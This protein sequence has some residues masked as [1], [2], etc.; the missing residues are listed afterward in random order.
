MVSIPACHAGDRGSIPRRGGRRPF[1]PLPP[2]T[3]RPLSDPVAGA[4]PCPA[5]PRPALPSALHLGPWRH[6][7]RGTAH[8]P[9]TFPSNPPGQGAWSPASHSSLLG[10]RQRLMS[11]PS[12][13]DG[14][15]PPPGSGSPTA[16]QRL[17]L[18]GARWRAACR[19]CA[20]S[21]CR[22]WPSRAS[23]SG[24]DVAENGRGL[25]SRRCGAGVPRGQAAAG[26]SGPGVALERPAAGGRPEEASGRAPPSGGAEEGG[27]GACGER[28]GSAGAGRR[29][30]VL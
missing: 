28:R 8:P 13:A 1:W 9:P 25:A 14:C 3:R 12:P 26:S 18:P 11:G 30:V 5:L 2:R 17:R 29:L 4:M 24:R 15:L 22:L 23:P 7:L 21:R 10:S 27:A 20:P 19:R 16:A 6:P